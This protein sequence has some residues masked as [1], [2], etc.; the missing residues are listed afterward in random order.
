MTRLRKIILWVLIP[1]ILLLTAL[2][3]PLYK[4]DFDI[5]TIAMTVS[6]VFTILV[7]FFIATAT[8]NYLNFNSYLADESAY[9][10]TI[11]NLG[12]LIQPSAEKKLGHAIDQY[13]IA[14]LDF[15]LISYIKNTDKE[16]DEIIKII[17]DLNPQDKKIKRTAAL[18]YI[19]EIKNNLFQTR[20]SILLTA[21]RTTSKIHW[22]VL[23]MLTLLLG[24][25]LLALRTG[26]IFSQI[27]I[28]IVLGALYLIL[29][30]LN[31]VDNDHF[32]EES[33]ALEDVQ[34]IFRVIGKLKYYPP[35]AFEKGYIKEP[36]ENYRTAVYKNYPYSTEK[37][38]VVVK[39]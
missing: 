33:V 19:Q 25:L 16:F 35:H 12:K 6:L 4:T 11:H 24:Y 36:L 14:S 22:V 26:E 20:Q 27:V 29:T 1:V 38:M 34:N 17:D 21:P 10:I 23:I 13:I 3:V 39:K 30:L 15:P 8:T 7:G 37:K 31:E 2:I 32:L 18:N 28:G 5:P 9:L